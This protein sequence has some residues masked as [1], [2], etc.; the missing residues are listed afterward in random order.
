LKTAEGEYRARTVDIS[1]GG[2]L[3][4]SEAV[5]P[6]G[7]PVQFTIEMPREALGTESSALV[8]CQG[9]VVRCSEEGSGWTVGVAIDD[10]EFERL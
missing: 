7:S 1:A 4:H 5:I 6:V 3:F 8:K 10:Y 9:R 2:I